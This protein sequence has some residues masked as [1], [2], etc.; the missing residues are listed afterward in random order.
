MSRSI[1]IGGKNYTQLGERVIFQDGV[2]KL[3][4][5]IE[6]DHTGHKRFGATFG[7]IGYKHEG[8][9]GTETVRESLLPSSLVDSS[10]RVNGKSNASMAYLVEPEYRHLLPN[11]SIIYSSMGKRSNWRR[12]SKRSYANYC[13]RTKHIGRAYKS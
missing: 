12:S 6:G 1:E 13:R 3:Q 10:I 11:W 4:Q 7:S 2:W 9:T 8:E 5:F